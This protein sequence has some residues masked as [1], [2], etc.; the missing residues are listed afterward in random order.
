MYI[1]LY[2]MTVYRALFHHASSVCPWRKIKRG[3]WCDFPG[4]GCTV[5]INVYLAAAVSRG[6]KSVV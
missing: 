5:K 3:N 1:K 2:I 6:R 4:A